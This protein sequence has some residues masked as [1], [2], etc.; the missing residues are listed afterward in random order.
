MS[1][2]KL[3]KDGYAFWNDCKSCKIKGCK[4]KKDLRKIAGLK[5]MKKLREHG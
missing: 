5:C 2:D 4:D 1:R 3:D